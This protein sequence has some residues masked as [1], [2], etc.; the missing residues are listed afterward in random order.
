MYL[1]IPLYIISNH[2][3]FPIAK[4]KFLHGV[5]DP[6]LSDNL[7]YDYL[8]NISSHHFHLACILGP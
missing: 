4:L 1:F 8:L 7:P 3:Y 2:F 6:A 5:N